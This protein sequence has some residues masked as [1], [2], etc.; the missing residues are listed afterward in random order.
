MDLGNW[1]MDKYQI[2]TPLLP[3]QIKE[4]AEPDQN[5]NSTANE[6]LEGLDELE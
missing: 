4:G 6:D 5:L 3:H 1:M 2:S